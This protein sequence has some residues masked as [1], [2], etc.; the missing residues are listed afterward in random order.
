MAASEHL[1]L[2][3]HYLFRGIICMVLAFYTSWKLTLV[4][5]ASFPVF[6][7]LIVYLSTNI[8]PSMD[9]QKAELVNACKVANNA[10]LS[11]EAVK[12]LNGQARESCSFSSRISN[13]TRHYCRQAWVNALQMGVNRFAVYAMIVQSFW[14]GHS[15][16]S[17]GE[18]APGD[19]LMT[20]W[21][22]MVAL[23]ALELVL[24]RLI[25]LEKGKL[26]GAA[27]KDTVDNGVANIEGG[28]GV[29]PSRCGG[30][31]E[32]RR[33]SSLPL[34]RTFFFFFFFWTSC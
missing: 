11:I 33:V 18:I 13:A 14:Y 31:I 16:K 32:V 21:A 22:C 4:T 6:S 19:V 3:V 23:Q 34:S 8:G 26:A 2:T 17:S 9:V 28:R 25:A 5:L 20:F 10:I 12:C 24:P 29:Y 1:G 27:L 15:L 7:V 30:D